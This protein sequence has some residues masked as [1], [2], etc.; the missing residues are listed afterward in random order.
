[1]D[2]IV[3]ED[4]S[5]R[6][7]RPKRS[8]QAQPIEVT[9]IEEHPPKSKQPQGS[10]Q[11][12][13]LEADLDLGV[14]QKS[15]G[16]SA[17]CLCCLDSIV[18]ESDKPIENSVTC[19]KGC[20]GGQFHAIPAGVAA[21]SVFEIFSIAKADDYSVVEYTSSHLGS[22]FSSP[23]PEGFSMESDTSVTPAVDECG[24]AT[25]PG[26]LDRCDLTGQGRYQG[27]AA[28]LSLPI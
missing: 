17:I 21:A 28:R 10:N 12:R 27:N 26:H 20:S 11:S 16:E 1:M 18:Q 5:K 2:N 13:K 22:L 24:D 14:F 23:E 4:P 9:L 15:P 8:F 19:T 7:P 3:F 25:I 6:R